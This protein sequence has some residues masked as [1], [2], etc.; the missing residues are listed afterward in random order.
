MVAGAAGDD[1]PFRE[2]NLH[3][4]PGGQ[5]LAV[6][7]GGD[8]EV[9]RGVHNN[10]APVAMKAPPFSHEGVNRPLGDRPVR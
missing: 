8:V 2:R 10:C 5:P 7:V 6:R 4:P 3:G 9:G 1:H